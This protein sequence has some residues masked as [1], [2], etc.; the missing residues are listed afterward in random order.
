M[1]NVL[2]RRGERSWSG[3]AAGFPLL[4]RRG[5]GPLPDAL[6]ISALVAGVTLASTYWPQPWGYACLSAALLALLELGLWLARKLLKRLLDHG[7]GWLMA[8]G[9]LLAAVSNTVKRGAGRVDLAG[10]GLL[11]PGDGGAVAAG[12]GPGGAC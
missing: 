7:L 4:R 8:L 9:L 5:A 11:R 1:T 6:A 12:G 3:A 10:V 2:T